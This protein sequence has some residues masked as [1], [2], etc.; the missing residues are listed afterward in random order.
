VPELRSL[1]F[2]YGSHVV[3]H[4]IPRRLAPR[5]TLGR[6]VQPLQEFIDTEAAGGL[7]LVFATIAAIVWANSPFSDSYENLLH[8]HVVLDLGF[9]TVD[10]PVH[11]WVND[12]LMVLFFFLVGMEIKRELVIGELSSMRQAIVPFAAAAGGMIVP[13][14]IFLLLVRDPIGQDGWGVPMATDIAF[15][16]GVAAL[17]GPRVP[18][19]LK[20][21]LLALAIFDDLGAVAVI[22]IAYSDAVDFGPLLLGVGL[23]TVVW[24]LGRMGVRELPVYIILGVLTWGAILESGVHPT[25]VGVALGVLTPLASRQPFEETQTEA[26]EV[27]DTF[28][29]PPPTSNDEARRQRIEALFRLRR[30]SDRAIAPLDRLEHQ[31]NHWVAFAIVPIFALANAGVDLRGDTLPTALEEGLTWG[32]AIGL[33]LGKPVGIVAASWIA[34]RLGARLP[35]DATWAGVVG[36]GALA[37]IGFTVALFVAQ[38]AYPEGPLLAQAKVGIFLG[39]IASGLVGYLLLRRL[40]AKPVD[41]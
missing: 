3:S 25:T 29:D 10:E 40:P 9:F 39:S 20:V 7:A 13:V 32:V 17:L 11:F 4:N 5:A 8:A 38:L 23:L 34:V 41:A 21:M 31:L 1:A 33:L 30:L 2:W 35:G 6:L 36:I 22:A 24:A 15:A 37:G 12:V 19:G 18:I 28:D 27:L 26:R 16:L 14:A